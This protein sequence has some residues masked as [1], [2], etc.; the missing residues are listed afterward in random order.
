[1]MA[2]LETWLL[3]YYALAFSCVVSG[4]CL[5]VPEDV[6]ILYAGLSVAVGRFTWIPTATIVVLAEAAAGFEVLMLKRSRRA[7]F[8]PRLR[9]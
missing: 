7:S 2:A 3:S 4:L 9:R 6:I 1:M 5:P 8:F